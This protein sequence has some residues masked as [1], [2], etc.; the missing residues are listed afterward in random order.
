MTNYNIAE[1][2]CDLAHSDLE[3][4]VWPL[5]RSGPVDIDI[6][7][8]M[9]ALPPKCAP[10]LVE[11]CSAQERGL[12]RGVGLLQ[13]QQEAPDYDG[14]GVDA[15]GNERGR[16]PVPLFVSKDGQHVIATA[17]RQLVLMDCYGSL[18]QGADVYRGMH[19]NRMKRM[20]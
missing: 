13:G 2:T 14:V 3:F 8:V 10:M 19:E 18:A 1:E 12:I 4:C 9:P 17:K 15:A 7:P 16:D 5:T 11:M 6:L 20:T